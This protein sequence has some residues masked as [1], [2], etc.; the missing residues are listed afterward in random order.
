[1]CETLKSIKK[2]ISYS[3]IDKLAKELRV[4]SGE[5]RHFLGVSDSDLLSKSFERAKN[6]S[7]DTS[8]TTNNWRTDIL[9]Y[10]VNERTEY[11]CTNTRYPRIPTLLDLSRLRFSNSDKLFSCSEMDLPKLNFKF[12]TLNILDY[13]HVLGFF[14]LKSNIKI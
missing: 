13:I 6:A 3:N 7:N 14:L 9:V 5:C 4:L 11:C 1:M 10:P 12:F 2:Q 8:W